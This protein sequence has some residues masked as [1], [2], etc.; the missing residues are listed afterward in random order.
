LTFQQ[1][2]WNLKDVLPAHAGPEFEAEVK[3]LQNDAERF[4]RRK[5]HLTPTIPATELREALRRYEGLQANDARFK[6]YAYLYFSQDTT[7]QDARTF[8]SRM[9]ELDAEVSNRTVFF[10]LWL[11]RLDDEAAKRLLPKLDKDHRYYITKLRKLKPHVLD[12]AVE[13][14]IKTK[15]TTGRM[16]L[17]QLYE[18]ITSAFEYTVWTDGKTLKDDKG[19]TKKLTRGELVRLVFGPDAQLRQAAYKALFREYLPTRDVLGEIYRT[20]V[21]D[22]RNEYIKTRHYQSPIAVFNM[23][24]DVPD[25]AVDT[26]LSTCRKNSA[27]FQEFFSMKAKLLHIKPMNRYHIYAPL[28]KSQKKILYPD[29]VDMV[30]EAYNSFHPRLGELAK[31]VFTEDHV[32]AEIRKGKLSGAYC[33]T[34][35][36]KIVPYVFVNYDDSITNVMSVGHEVGHALHAMLASGH[37]Q[38]TF[39]APTALAEIA[40]IFGELILTEKLMEEEE[41]PQT[42]QDLLVLVLSELYATVPR[43]AYF[44]VFEKEAHTAVDQGATVDKLADIYIAG[45]REQFGDAVTVPREFKWEWVTIPHIYRY[46]FYCWTYSF[47]NLVTLGLYNM[48]KEEGDSFKPKYIKLLSYGGSASPGKVLSE[49]GVDIRSEEFWQGGFQIIKDM[50]NNLKKLEA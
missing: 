49:V 8:K 27:V 42:R 21:R 48:F 28:Q 41:D 2:S 30:L 25:E 18:Q 24:N 7:S 47:G 6:W 36:P 14:A 1:K 11:T 3:S 12:E 40:S 17:I 44:V 26:L 31:R 20:L 13:Q 5:E 16:A 50:I 39:H 37:S 10:D 9:D 35:T 32:D 33:M 34:I 22:W 45:L 38:L 29:A 46:P 15:N 4:E 19:Q 43:Q 23:A